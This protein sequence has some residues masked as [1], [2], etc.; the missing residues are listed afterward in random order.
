LRAQRIDT[1]IQRMNA[2]EEVGDVREL[3]PLVANSLEKEAA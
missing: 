2:L 3:V 1:L